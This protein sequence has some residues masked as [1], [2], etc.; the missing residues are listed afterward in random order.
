VSRFRTADAKGVVIPP[1]EAAFVQPM[2]IAYEEAEDAYVF[3]A[4]GDSEIAGYAIKIPANAI[5]ASR[6]G[7]PAD[8]LRVS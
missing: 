6:T 5:L 4:K 3:V 1:G 7:V 2:L 8:K